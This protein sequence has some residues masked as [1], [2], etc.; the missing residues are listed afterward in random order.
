MV[1][2]MQN[3][4]CT[5]HTDITLSILI[6]KHVHYLW[7]NML[8]R[9][10]VFHC[11]DVDIYF[12]VHVLRNMKFWMIQKLNVQFVKEN[13]M[14]NMRNINLIII[15]VYLCYKNNGNIQDI[16]FYI[17]IFG[18]I[19]GKNIKI[20][21]KRSQKIVKMPHNIR[22]WFTGDASGKIEYT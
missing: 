12:I 20:I 2:I 19:H 17:I 18:I 3:F 8:L 14:Y 1:H 6:K 13:M 4:R 9:Q 7:K 21:R 10:I 16:K 15:I 5:A 11:Y 22:S